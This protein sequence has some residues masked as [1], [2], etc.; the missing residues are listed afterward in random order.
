MTATD[1]TL[2]AEL[3]T[4]TGTTQAHAL[5]AAG[6]LPA[7]LYGHGAQAQH[8]SLDARV[9]DEVLHR[10]GRTGIVTL[11]TG[12]KKETALVR[13][14]QRHP[15]TQRI[16]HADLQRVSA[17]EAVH[18]RLPVVTVGTARGVRDSGGVMDVIVH[19]LEIEGPANRIPE[20]VE[21]D[22]R[23]LALHG[24]LT[25]GDIVLPK[26]FTM[27]TPADTIVVAIEASRTAHDL[28]EAALG[29]PEQAEPEVISQVSAA[30]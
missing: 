18:A 12:G 10:G 1:L 17:N 21:A 15:V 25:A 27:V 19:D 16:V 5:R 22:V 2:D 4:K 9:F 20:H 11:K 23:E 13:D 24:H 26:G 28:E 6:R 30:E 14:L 7:V 3:R 29:T 8:L